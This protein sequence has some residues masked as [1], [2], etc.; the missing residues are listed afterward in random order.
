MHISSSFITGHSGE[1]TG[2]VACDQY[3]KYKVSFFASILTSLHRPIHGLILSHV[4]RK[5]WSSWKT[6]DWRLINFPYPGHGFYLVWFFHNLILR[7]NPNGYKIFLSILDFLFQV[8]ENQLIQR[9]YNTTTILL[10]NWSLMV[11]N[12]VPWSCFLATRLK[13]SILFNGVSYFFV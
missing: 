2:D 7:T 6:L 11:I 12:F 4:F 5:M 1:A 13:K 8:E 10:M 3:H 9:G